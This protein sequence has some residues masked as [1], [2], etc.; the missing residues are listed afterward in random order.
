MTQACRTIVVE[1]LEPD[2]LPTLDFLADLEEP[3]TAELRAEVRA[4]VAGPLEQLRH[5]LDLV[6]LAARGADPE[7]ALHR[8]RDLLRG[9][10]PAMKDLESQ[11]LGR[12]PLPGR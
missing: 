3:L 5:E 6:V 1:L 2:R 11:L 7:F 8:L 9:V 4:A 12:I 10:P